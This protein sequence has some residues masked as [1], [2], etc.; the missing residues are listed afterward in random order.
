V[1]NLK[2]DKGS[3]DKEFIDNSKI[4]ECT[5][6][7]SED[8]SFTGLLGNVDYNPYFDGFV[9]IKNYYPSRSLS[10]KELEKYNYYIIKVRIEFKTIVKIKDV[11]FDELYNSMGTTFDF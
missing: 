7:F 5:P 3:I 6:F 1:V 10:I 8:G 9:D 2:R 4:T 11:H